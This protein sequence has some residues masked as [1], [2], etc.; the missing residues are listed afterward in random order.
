MFPASLRQNILLFVEELLTLY[1]PHLTAAQLDLT[2]AFSE[3]SDR[4]Q[5]VCETQ[6]ALPNPLENEDGDLGAMILR[7]MSERVTYL[8]DAGKSTLELTLRPPTH[9]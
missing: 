6:P 8:R 4:L 5:L 3:K 2:V 1:R 9:Q 7:N